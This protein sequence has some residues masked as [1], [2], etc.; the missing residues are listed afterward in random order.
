M[1]SPPTPCLADKTEANEQE[2]TAV[3][4]RLHL[5]TTSDNPGELKKNIDAADRFGKS[6]TTEMLRSIGADTCR[7]GGS[8][9]IFS[10]SFQD[11]C[12]DRNYGFDDPN[13]GPSRKNVVCRVFADLSRLLNPSGSLPDGL[14][15]IEILESEGNGVNVMPFTQLANASPVILTGFE[16]GIA[17][18][19]VLKTIQSGVDAYFGLNHLGYSSASFHGYVRYNFADHS[20]YSDDTDFTTSAAGSNSFDLYSATLHEAIHLLGFYSL[21][22]GE[23]PEKISLLANIGS[24]RC[25]SKYDTYL[26]TVGGI[27]TTSNGTPFYLDYPASGQPYS[28]NVAST[29]PFVQDPR[30]S[31][32]VEFSGT[33]NPAQELFRPF[34]WSGSGISHLN[35]DAQSPDG[36]ATNNGYLMNSCSPLEYMQRY[37]H[38]DEVAILCDLGYG[39]S[40]TYGIESLPQAGSEVPYFE[41]N[42]ICG[43]GGCTAVGVNDF[44]SQ[45]PNAGDTIVFL[46]SDFL[47]NDVNEDGY[48]PNSFEL[49]DPALGQVFDN[50]DGFT[51]IANYAGPV[52]IR[53]LPRCSDGNPGTWAYVVIRFLAWTLEGFC[54]DIPSCNLICRG[55]FEGLPQYQFTAFYNYR[56]N[57]SQN[58]GAGSPD[59]RPLP[60][61]N[62][63]PPVAPESCNHE[64]QG[65]D[66]VIFTHDGCSSMFAGFQSNNSEGLEFI[67][68]RS[69]EEDKEYVLSFYLNASCANTINFHFSKEKA[70]PVIDSVAV[71]EVL[72]NDLA[73]VNCDGYNFELGQKISISFNESDPD[74]DNVLEWV[75]YEVSFTA[76]DVYRYVQVYQDVLPLDENGVQRWSYSYIDEISLVEVPAGEAHFE[77]EV[78]N[79][80]CAGEAVD[81]EVRICFDNPPEEM[82]L[83]AIL[84]TPT[85]LAFFGSSGDFTDGVTT[86]NAFSYNGNQYCDTAILNM[87]I[88]AGLAPGTEI[89]IRVASNTACIN[90]PACGPEI[91][92][93]AGGEN[94]AGFEYSVDECGLA[95]FTSLGYENDDHYWEFGNP[96]LGAS[97]EAHPEF[98][99]MFPGTYSVFHQIG[100]GCGVDTSTQEV[101]IADSQA[102]DASFNVVASLNG[103]AYTFTSLNHQPGGQHTWNFG[104]GSQQ[105][106]GAEAFHI[107]LLPGAYTVTHTVVNACGSHT[108]TIT[109][110]AAN[111]IDGCASCNGSN[112]VGAPGAQTTIT[113]ALGLGILQPAGTP[114]V[115]CVAGDLAVEENT[116]YHF[117]NSVVRMLEGARILVKKD[118][119]LAIHNSFFHG[120]ST[121]WRG[122][123]VEKGG[124]LTLKTNNRIDDAQYAIYVH[125]A[126][127]GEPVP[128]VD[129]ETNV[130][131][132]NFVGI[133]MA[134]T[135]AGSV[136]AFI[137][138]NGFYNVENLLPPFQGQSSAPEGL[139]QQDDGSLNGIYLNK[140]SG[141]SCTNNTFDGLSSGI[142]LNS[143][144]GR[145]YRNAFTSVELGAYP[146]YA[147]E[148]EAVAGRGTGGHA[149]AVEACT[150][151]NCHAGIVAGQVAL[152]AVSND[153]N[154][155][156]F[157]V[158]A[159]L[160]NAGNITIGGAGDKRNAIH[161]SKVGI[162]ANH[163]GTGQVSIINNEISSVAEDW[164]GGIA[165][166]FNHAPATVKENRLEAYGP[167]SGMAL[168]SCS[169]AQ[170][171]NNH[172]SLMD[173]PD[174]RAGIALD[175]SYQ[176]LLQEDTVMGQGP[177][178]SENI[179]IALQFSPDNIYCCNRVSNTRIGVQV[180]AS[181][182][183]ENNFRGTEFG[184]HATALLLDDTGILGTQV[185][186]KNRWTG[187]G[188]AEYQVNFLQAQDYQFIVDNTPPN[189]LPEYF[190]PS[191]TPNG[192]FDPQEDENSL[193]VCLSQNCLVDG[194]E[195]ESTD[196]KRIAKGEIEAGEYTDIIQ[197]H[198]SRFLYR[199]L[200]GYIG[201]DEDILDFIE[202]SGG[203]SV[204]AFDALEE[205]TQALLAE[206]IENQ[207]LVKANLAIISAQLKEIGELDSLYLEADE[208][209]QDSLRQ[210]REGLLDSIAILALETYTVNEAVNHQRSLSAA[211]LIQ[212]NADIETAEVYEDNLKTVNDIFLNYLQNGFGEIPAEELGILQGIALQCPLE[213]GGAVFSGRALLAIAARQVSSYDDVECGGGEGQR[214]S[215]PVDVRPEIVEMVAI[216]P[217]PAKEQL[218][219]DWSRSETP[220]VNIQLLDIY[221]KV[222][223]RIPVEP[224]PGHCV[225]ST[226]YL[227][228]GLYM[229]RVQ[230]QHGEVVK[231]VIINP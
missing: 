61:G 43:P 52:A 202:I 83:H 94:E 96:A 199:K 150:F 180:T 209:G 186:M 82:D 5:L 133:Y 178:G 25:Y 72:R 210:E 130:F 131:A 170:L 29:P 21:I 79:Q 23:S 108:E 123:E 74:G 151:T 11:I 15:R 201:E 41:Y 102:P 153:M 71:G 228:A 167:T 157:G 211:S 195:P 16:E 91:L 37:P 100:S 20:F 136:K 32:D 116:S 98:N 181:C 10:L 216:Y 70:C 6:Y 148:G 207:L 122:I 208:S 12:N 163:T 120:C 101:V 215:S 26:R 18:G 46:A 105:V 86:L 158:T 160:S 213:G 75:K 118:G 182:Q 58:D 109:L 185:H 13:S 107:F 144:N 219:V 183:A 9:G 152:S 54:E 59:L 31:A 35:C 145:I 85:F 194:F 198:L 204:G 192:W 214:P 95:S 196:S 28:V 87:V 36:C 1:I 27:T 114:Q 125:A 159:S 44:P 88:G 45:T 128:F 221:G 51:L 65:E 141:F 48:I 69:M 2:K 200:K 97:Q 126:A 189:G 106:A 30:C 117:A 231:K 40:G 47:A 137:D 146:A 164:G 104:D 224:G 173:M 38:P 174:A 53:Y 57:Q 115:I 222:H 24:P 112:T 92:L 197:W 78:L 56:I 84:N 42:N 63:Y 77:Y 103:L 230:Y 68:T 60:G 169:K 80:P 223:Q 168:W 140:L 76:T 229:V 119:A 179:G 89:P 99:F 190:P 156:E 19:Q 113:E 73:M 55:D 143:T 188:G 81:I 39:L 129:V 67:L 176:C 149:L 166:F 172:I 139:P 184:G 132:D 191:V 203:N 171:L 14:V 175:N 62:W 135:A 155:V 90:S 161:K 124:S 64:Y 147:F 205:G 3:L 93:V 220:A 22:N 7:C 4:R 225:L 66:G 193:N 187:S 227:K 8:S 165:L 206:D 127:D 33:A 111:P 110:T 49:V 17:A 121:M 34:P 217:N 142:V 134:G 226:S 154:E 50:G 212:Q 138:G 177:G 218:T 162:L